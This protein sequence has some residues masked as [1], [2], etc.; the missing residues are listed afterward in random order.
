MATLLIGRWLRLR[1]Q[2]ATEESVDDRPCAKQI[3][4]RRE[5]AFAVFGRR[6]ERIVVGHLA[7]GPT[8]GNERAA[9]IGKHHEQQQDTAALDLAH[10]C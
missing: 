4:Q 5:A 2:A 9:A 3:S 10:N 7:V 6:F 8:G 1:N